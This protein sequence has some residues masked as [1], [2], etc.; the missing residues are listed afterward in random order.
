MKVLPD[1]NRCPSIQD[2]Y[3]LRYME[4][5]IKETFR[6]YPPVP[7]IGRTVHEETHL[8]SEYLLNF[9][10]EDNRRRN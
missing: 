10:I 8:P 3:N 7:M 5:V 4:K 9:D 1:D 2:L 6:L